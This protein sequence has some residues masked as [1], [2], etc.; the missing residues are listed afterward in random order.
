MEP[1]T[2][3]GGFNGIFIMLIV[4]MVFFMWLNGRSQKKREAE[5]QKTIK[6]LQKGDKIVLLGGVIGIVAGFS[7]ELIEVKVSE[8]VKLSVLPS[9]VVSAYNKTDVQTV[10]GA[11]K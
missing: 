2:A 3:A 11:K 10:E 7:G 8:N 6:N 4:F 9:G 5:R 1:N